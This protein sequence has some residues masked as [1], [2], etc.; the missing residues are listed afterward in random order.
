MNYDDYIQRMNAKIDPDKMKFGFQIWNFKELQFNDL[1]ALH[2][3]ELDK[4]TNDRNHWRDDSKNMLE[5]FLDYT[6]TIANLKTKLKK[7]A[8]AS[9][10]LRGIE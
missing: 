6:T 4:I 2:K 7:V 10:I 9:R 5:R 3:I 8:E 1:K